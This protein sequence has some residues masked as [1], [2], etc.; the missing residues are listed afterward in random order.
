MV[1]IPEGS[2]VLSQAQL[3]ELIASRLQE[4]QEKFAQELEVFNAAATEVRIIN[5]FWHALPISE[6]IFTTH[7]ILMVLN[8]LF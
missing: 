6:Y 3:D 5:H 8:I 7:F 4:E 1:L 2:F